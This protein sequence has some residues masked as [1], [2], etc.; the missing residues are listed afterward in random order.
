MDRGSRRVSLGKITGVH[1]VQGWVKV[2]SNTDPRKAIFDYQP[3]YIGAGSD[4]KAVRVLQGRV[5]GKTLAAQ[6]DVSKS[7][8]E[9]HDLIGA[10]IFIPMDQFP[11]L[12]DGEYYWFDLEG[13]DVISESGYE[14]GKVVKLFSTGAN[15]VVVVKGE[16]E[17]LIPY[18]SGQYIKSVDLAANKMLVDWDPDF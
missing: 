5:Q 2:F 6:I 14:F 18:V 3:W 11:Q 9:A 15:D 13:L 12:P 10:E 7:R 8:E 16:K 1:G 4:V 17:H